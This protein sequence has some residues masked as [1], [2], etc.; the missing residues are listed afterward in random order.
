MTIQ[1]YQRDRNGVQGVV[2][3]DTTGSTHHLGGG[4]RRGLFE[5]RRSA[6]CNHEGRGRC[7]DDRLIAG[8]F[9]RCSFAGR[10]CPYSGKY[11]Y[12]LCG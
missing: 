5:S 7:D 10:D 4:H 8:Q 9:A 12:V 6:A 1:V 11:D 2:N 3:T